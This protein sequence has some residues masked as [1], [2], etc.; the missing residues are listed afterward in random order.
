[1]KSN[2]VCWLPKGN[3]EYIFKL[4]TQIKSKSPYINI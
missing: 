3:I 2:I 4:L 1:M